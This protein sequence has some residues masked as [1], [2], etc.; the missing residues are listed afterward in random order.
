M[1]V[2]SEVLE[3]LDATDGQ[4]NTAKISVVLQ[5]S[6]V[7]APKDESQGNRQGHELIWNMLYGI[8]CIET[9]CSLNRDLIT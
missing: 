1:N 4:T 5:L 7:S 8:S 3:L 2:C 6:V 9:A